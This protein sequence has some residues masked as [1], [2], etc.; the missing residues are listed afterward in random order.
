MGAYDGNSRHE[1]SYMQ[2]TRSQWNSAVDG[3][4]G[5][6]VDRLSGL[7]INDPSSK[8]S[9]L[10]VMKAVE[11]AE[12][13]IKQQLEENN[14]LRTELQKKDQELERYKSDPSTSLQLSADGLTHEH[15]MGTNKAH[16]P[17]S[18]T[19]N[20]DRFRWANNATPDPQ[21]TLIIHNNVIP[22]NEEPASQSHY[23][24]QHYSDH[25]KVNGT[26]EVHSSGKV[27]VDN[28]GFSQF[29]PP[30][31]RSFSP[32]GFPKDGD[33][34]P[35]FSLSGQGLMP[36]SE[37]NNPTGLLKQ[38]LLFKVREHEEEIVQLRKHLADYS[39]KEAQI[40]NEKYVLEKRIAYMRLAFDQQQQ[41]LVDAA[42]KALSYR[43]DIIEENIRLTYALQAAQQER[44]TF[45]SSL[46]PLLQEYGFQPSVADAQSIVNNLKV[47]FKHLQEKLIITEAKLKESQYQLA[48]WR[49]DALVNNTNF[50]PQSP[51][52][53]YGV[54]LTTTTK[55]GLE[56]VPQQ[57]Y[58]HSQTPSSSPLNAQTTRIAEWDMY[59]RNNNLPTS[60]V[61]MKDLEHDNLGRYSPPAGRSP[62]VQG[63][64]ARHTPQGDAGRLNDEH[65]NR[66]LSSSMNE[67]D[68]SDISGIP[69]KRE[70]SVHWAAGTVSY[71]APT[72]EDPGS[73]YS[74]YLPP[75]LEEPSSSFS[76]AADD[77]PLPA[78][79][80][81]QI[82][83]EAFPGRELQACGYSI[84][85]TTSCN[86]EWVRYLE[87]GSVH[88]IVG[89][90][91]P[92]Y[93]VTADDVD[94][95]LAIEVQPLDNRKRKGELVKVFANDQRK[96][97]CDSDMQGQIEKTLSAGHVSYEV[98]LSAGC[99]D[100]WEPAILAIKRE[101]YS[102]K[103]NGPRG[104]V[105]A[106]K[107]FPTTSV[108]IPFGHSTEFS[109]LS[110]SGVE[111][112]LRT[113]DSSSLRDIIVLTLRL[114]IMRAVEKRKGKKKGLFF[115]K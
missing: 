74:P 60:G 9:L 51:T 90:K 112:L 105:V 28:I 43:Q 13:T 101:G 42:S 92:N 22:K 86:F 12:N 29:S 73:S 69:A 110:S 89:A 8:E 32:S 17:F 55:N 59:G 58:S 87:D 88:Y 25:G 115:T 99:L 102:I 65:S 84:N 108:T 56:I 38:E 27:G 19:E 1:I 79:E 18:P 107:F 103:C 78:I 83:G 85:G 23:E 16:L 52:H 75:V 5:N 61:V 37:M 94:S 46:L 71:M 76:E 15:E 50:T 96:I 14:L 93:L 49:S 82:A 34:D 62:A 47:L 6:L 2:N 97:T 106:E 31:S 114:F 33:N 109:V 11:A 95:Y 77:D 57:P 64:P 81:L 53:S 113:A 80:G 3:G 100:I 104:V 111:Y 45:I 44:S 63:T 54:A 26:L 41:D 30:S 66:P 98:S 36:V 39:M 72:Q 48:P 40:R 70:P 20:G 67:G 24:N 7:G 68:E 35:K 4:T 10:Q 91:Q 21:G